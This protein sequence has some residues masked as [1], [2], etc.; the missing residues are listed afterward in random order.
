MRGIKINITRRAYRKIVGWSVMN[1]ATIRPGPK[2]K[3]RKKF[4]NNLSNPRL[5]NKVY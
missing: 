3:E 1:V 4:E 5:P 2:K